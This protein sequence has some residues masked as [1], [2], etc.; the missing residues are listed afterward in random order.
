VL[1]R[2]A[3]LASAS[4]PDRPLAELLPLDSGDCYKAHFPSGGME[5]DESL[6]TDGSRPLVF[7]PSPATPL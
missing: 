1:L 2:D 5:P 7:T 6:L 3:S 4:P